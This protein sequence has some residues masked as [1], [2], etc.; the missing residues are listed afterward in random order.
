MFK[1]VNQAKKVSR[2]N[3][4][5]KSLG[6]PYHDRLGKSQ[7]SETYAPFFPVDCGNG[8][9]RFEYVKTHKI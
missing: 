8:Y 5:D 6:I 3:L 1:V 2:K 9:S 4:A 7:N